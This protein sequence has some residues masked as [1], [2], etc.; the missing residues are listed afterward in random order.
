MCDHLVIAKVLLRWGFMVFSWQLPF[1]FNTHKTTVLPDVLSTSCHT[2][3]ME[4]TPWCNWVGWVLTSP[5]IETKWAGMFW[6]EAD[7]T[8]GA[9]PVWLQLCT[10]SDCWY[11]YLQKLKHPANNIRNITK[12]NLS[13]IKQTHSLV[14]YRIRCPSLKNKFSMTSH[15]S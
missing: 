8:N 7:C 1:T 13:N 11:L 14:T 6:V 12:P 3:T 4:L 15:G 9:Y 2:V 10:T 5:G